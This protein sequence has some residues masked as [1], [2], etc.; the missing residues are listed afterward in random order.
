[1]RVL[2]LGRYMSLESRPRS[3]EVGFDGFVLVLLSPSQIDPE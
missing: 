1:M 2:Q 3:N